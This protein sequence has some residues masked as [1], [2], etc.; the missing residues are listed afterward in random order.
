MNKASIIGSGIGGLAAAIRLRLKGYKVVVFEA[1]SSFGGKAAEIKKK[2]FRF[3]KGPSL[4]TMPE[5]IDELF[6]L[7]K[8]NPKDYFN[9]NKLNE[10]CRYFYEDGTSIVAHAKTTDFA[11]EV[12]EKT[13]VSK[14]TII[15]Y[16]KHNTFVFNSTS[17][18]FLEKS[19]HKLTS[20]LSL[21]VF[22]SFLKIPF[23]NLFSSMN[24]VN[25]KKFKNK[26][27][28]QLFNR[29]YYRG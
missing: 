19:L 15:E 2:G 21:K 7:A 13:R 8:K 20:Y 23:L 10:S 28:T 1:N 4:L 11:K 24:K 27:I 26:K 5:K 6:Y 22:Y 18:L 16:I 17:H 9:Y 12:Y 3:D 14:R 25:N 29:C